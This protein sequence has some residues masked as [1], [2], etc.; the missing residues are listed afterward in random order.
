MNI[1]LWIVLM[2]SF[3]VA[4]CNAVAAKIETQRRYACY[5]SFACLAF[6]AFLIIIGR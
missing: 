6:M 5:I 2:V 1:V 4:V 3:F